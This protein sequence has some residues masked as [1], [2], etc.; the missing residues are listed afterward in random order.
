MYIISIADEDGNLIGLL[1]LFS[2][3]TVGIAVALVIFCHHDAT[4]H[5]LLSSFSSWHPPSIPINYRELFL[6]CMNLNIQSG[7]WE[8]KY[9]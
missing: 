5:E 3:L 6:I 2:L 7:F 1:L 9:L 8:I 4:C